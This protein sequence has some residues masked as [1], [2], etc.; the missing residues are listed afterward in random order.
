[1]QKYKI[2]ALT[3]VHFPKKTYLR[4]AMS[5]GRLGLHCSFH[6][7]SPFSPIAHSAPVAKL[8][9]APDLGSGGLCRV[10]SSPIRRTTTLPR[11]LPRSR[12]GFFYV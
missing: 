12:R 6:I 3:L 5:L 11:L 8:V 7:C 1:M 9:D 2:F 10:G 4:A